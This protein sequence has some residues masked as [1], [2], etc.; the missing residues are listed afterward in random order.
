M[1][2]RERALRCAMTG[3]TAA[4]GVLGLGLS[5]TVSAQPVPHSID[6]QALY[7]ASDY[8]FIGEAVGNR[9]VVAM[10][11]SIHLTREMPTVRRNLIRYLN[12]QR[13][14]DAL[15][16]EGALIDAWTAQ[17]HA[18]RSTAPAAERART[19]TREALFGLWQTDEMIA[20]VDYALRS[21]RGARP[22]Y[23]A[24]FD[25]QPG[26]ARAYG[27]SSSAS[28]AAF[29]AALRAADPTLE[30][31]RTEAWLKNL[32]EALGCQGQA[33]AGAVEPLQQWISNRAAQV[34]GNRPPQH[35]HA[36]RQVPLMIT[37]RLQQCAAGS[38]AP[39]GS[40]TYQRVRDEMNA[41]LVLAL[42]PGMPRMVLW[43][44]NG[45]L[46][47]NSLGRAIPSMGQHLKEKLGDDLYTIGLF[48]GG[49]AAVDSV[50]AD[51]AQGLAAITAM[52]AGPVPLDKRFGVE[53]RLAT[54]APSDFFIDLSAT[55]AEWA[56][57]DT[58]RLEVDGTMATALSRDFDG[59]VF[60]H[61]V[62]GAEMNFI[63]GFVR[64]GLSALGWV[65]NHAMLAALLASGL[66]TLILLG[67][68]GLWRK[69]RRRHR[70]RTASMA[71]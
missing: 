57:S 60:L 34:F 14:V 17:E 5:S 9:P 69:R 71:A 58:S 64:G 4:A 68:R 52:A 40:P 33:P 53:Q 28:F 51:S 25:I 47:H 30:K 8:K 12:E 11:E 36:L 20:V 21:Q 24:S 3:V 45:H 7:R 38:A 1:G 61:E 27:G 59:A 66:L 49:G 55:P 54:L 37:S 50:R 6:L 23:I 13:G 41:K 35:L 62:T 42:R 46:H 18:Y 70:A 63:P 15:A 48:A 31:A 65:L 56:R 32:G 44:H 29:L 10:G 22:L 67:I 43:A 2:L 39:K 19:F 16:F 26:Q